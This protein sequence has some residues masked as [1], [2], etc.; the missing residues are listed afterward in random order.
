MKVSTKSPFQIVYSLFE[1]QYLGYLFESFVVEVNELNNLTL[2]Y[3]NISSMNAHEFGEGLDK[4]DFKL[5]KLMD[6]CSQEEIMKRFYKKKVLPS[7]F[8][9]TVYET[10]KD[11]ALIEIIDSY[12]ERKRSK[13]LGLLEGKM[14]FEMGNDGDPTYKKINVEKEK[15]SIL[16][17]FRRNDENTHYFPTIKFKGEKLEFR[18]RN[19]IILCNEPAWMM[20]EG[21]LISFH[22]KLDGKKLKP[23]LNKKFIAIPKSM[24][25]TYYKKFISQMIESFNVTAKGFDIKNLLTDAR[26]RLSITELLQSNTANLFESKGNGKSNGSAK[27]NSKMVFKLSFRY[28]DFK[29]SADQ[30]NPASVKMKHDSSQD[31]YTFYKV[32]RDI[33]FESKTREKL[34]SL[35]LPIN[36]GKLII[37][38]SKA[39]SFISEHI[40]ALER[41]GFQIEQ[42][43]ESS[44]KKYFL[45][46]S[47]INVEIT[48]NKDWFDINAI[49]KFGDYEIPFI[50]L[51]QLIVA[52]KNEFTLPNGETAVIPESWFTR[53]S[54]L[55]QFVDEDNETS[56]LKKHHVALVQDLQ[57]DNLAQVTMS[58]KLEKL[59]D[60]SQIDDFDLSPN[61]NGVL[62]P[63]QKAG[64]NWLQFLSQYNFGGCLADDM[65]LGKTVQTLAMLQNEK[66]QGAQNATLLIMPTSLLYNWEME[67]KKFTPNLKVF[68]Y[69]GSSREKNVEIF[70]D[71]DLILTSYGIARIDSDILEEYYFN[72][73]ILDESQ[74]IKNP[75]S[76]IAKSVSRLKSKKRLILTGT[77]IENTTLDLWSQLSFVNPGLLGGM[78][79]FK[80]EYQIPIEKKNDADKSQRLHALIKPFVLRRHKS[81]VAK[82]LPE[83]IEKVQY[84]DMTAEQEKE[85]EE[86][87]SYY[88]N[89]ILEH[90]EQKGVSRSQIMLLQ[91]LTLL[92]QLANHPKMVNV[93]SDSESGKMQSVLSMLETAI[94]EKHKILIF[95]QFVK[96]LGIFKEYLD[97]EK[98]K[99]AYLDGATKNRQEE[100]DN[101]QSDEDMRVFLISLKAGGLGLNLTAADYVFILDPWWNPAIEA[102]AV[103]RAHRIGQE[104]KVFTY[105]FI[106]RNTVE[107]KILALQENKLKLAQDLI[108]T[109]D[110]FIKSLSQND[111]EAL[112][113]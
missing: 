73:V 102:Q 4:T 32:K 48:E 40:E 18:Y 23:F 13:I 63:Y 7:Q 84:C 56:M 15:A 2:K 25:G 44:G 104:N 36:N 42:K 98:V 10:K 72:Y 86:T 53:Y 8:F 78:K 24:E 89:K 17:H 101:F 20:L 26:P 55:F 65:G 46:Q 66:D 97:K 54:D 61:F 58:R 74:I 83:K 96:H 110:T 108:T 95:S 100:V 88:R 52:N 21:K 105:K 50:K 71:Y 19:A 93:E 5:I 11:D 77:P 43:V 87:K 81:Q 94:S 45:G 47:F 16:F 57:T 76:I 29:F 51:R 49:V 109:E 60:F 82:D 103:D 113:S 37:D 9:E 68:C 14:V 85:Y 22:Q 34:K 33:D 35:G 62:R 99:Y 90:I 91:G 79:Y 39:F 107:E 41:D 12:L 59:R 67:A 3:Q 92:R 30:P 112:L 80:Q 28:G 6:E 27:D 31:S 1:H 38:K 111:I 70:Q 64:Y 75:N 106:T 69:T